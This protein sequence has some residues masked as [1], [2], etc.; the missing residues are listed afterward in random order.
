MNI[1]TCSVDGCSKPLAVSGLAL[2]AKHY[3]DHRLA[4][5]TAVCSVRGCDRKATAPNNMC[6][7]HYLRLRKFGDVGSANALRQR[8]EGKCSVAIC[9]NPSQA[10]G[11][12]HAHLARVK[13]HGETQA[14]IPIGKVPP[15]KAV[16]VCKAPGCDRNGGR[17]GVC[18]KH[19]QRFRKNGTYETAIVRPQPG[20]YPLRGKGPCII[21]GCERLAFTRGMCGTHYSRCMKNE[22]GIE[23]RDWAKYKPR[24][25][26][27]NGYVQVGE[28]YRSRLQHRV[29]AEKQLGRKLK[30]G[31]NVHHRNGI[32]NDNSIGPCLTNTGCDCVGEYHNLELWVVPPRKGQRVKDLLKFAHHIID[33]Y[34]SHVTEKS[35]VNELLRRIEA[36]K[37]MLQATE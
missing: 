34:E 20:T 26:K 2:C 13:R 18:E 16:T 33:T 19:Y 9:D 5:V 4:L 27:S 1:K 24:I 21:D 25:D 23:I 6:N 22:K 11:L 28:G 29:F 37:A 3:R 30:Q 7:M 17:K 10:L 36:N 12:C 31:E 14:D 32:R 35:S 15:R 8:Q